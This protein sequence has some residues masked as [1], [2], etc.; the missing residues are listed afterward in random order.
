METGLTYT[1]ETIV[2]NS[3]TAATMGSGDLAVFALWPDNW[4]Q[5]P[6]P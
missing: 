6:P 4:T 3:N 1:S 2:D 5:A